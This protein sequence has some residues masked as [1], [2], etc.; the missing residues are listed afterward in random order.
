MRS[1]K[2]IPGWFR[3]SV[4]GSSRSSFRVVIALAA[5]M[6][7][8]GW[9]SSVAAV[10]CVVDDSYCRDV[11]LRCTYSGQGQNCCFYTCGPDDSCTEAELQP[12]SEC[13]PPEVKIDL[14]VHSGAPGC[15]LPEAQTTVTNESP[16]YWYELSA[17]TTGNAV[18]VWGCSE[19]EVTVNDSNVTLGRSDE[20][21]SSLTQLIV[22]PGETSCECPEIP[23]MG[24]CCDNCPWASRN[25]PR[26]SYHCN[27][28]T[29][30]ADQYCAGVTQE[31]QVVKWSP[32][33][34]VWKSYPNPVLVDVDL[35]TS[36]CSP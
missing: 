33:N 29:P 15:T 6:F 1:R 36:S 19:C 31:V 17:W 10:T 27:A 22:F 14:R 7:C 2:R 12:M 9:F 18:G 25:D 13:S 24:G 23:G 8:V 34:Q 21:N 28:T 5:A 35:Y 11:D 30:H 4:G 32:D 3:C 16:L 20:P 26:C